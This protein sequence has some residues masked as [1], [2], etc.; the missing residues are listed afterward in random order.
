MQQTEDDC[1]VHGFPVPLQSRCGNSG[2]VT[3]WKRYMQYKKKNTRA[4]NLIFLFE[5]CFL[6]LF[7]G[8]FLGNSCFFPSWSLPALW[9]ST[10]NQTPQTSL[11][12]LTMSRTEKLFQT[13][14][15]YPAVLDSMW[16]KHPLCDENKVDGEWQSYLKT[17]TTTTTKPP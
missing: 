7:L 14:S 3:I 6:G 5:A 1:Q 17:K 13:F 15:V 2:F 9:N 11:L 10:Q 12:S 16:K 4:R 8:S